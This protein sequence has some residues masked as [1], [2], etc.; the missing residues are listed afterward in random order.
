[1]PRILIGDNLVQP[2]DIVSISERDVT[3]KIKKK[4]PN[5]KPKPKGL[6]SKAF[7]SST[8]TV[9]EEHKYHILVLKVKAGTQTVLPDPDDDSDFSIGTVAYGTHQ[10]YSFYTVCNNADFVKDAKALEEELDK[11]DPGWD[12]TRHAEIIRMLKELGMERSFGGWLNHNYL[13]SAIMI[14]TGVKT[15][16]DFIDK[17]M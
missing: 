2:N 3:L 8:V 17:Y 4:K 13:D 12:E 6:L 1:M 9:K 16:Q 7:Y 11:I 14:D 15:K 10:L 5:S